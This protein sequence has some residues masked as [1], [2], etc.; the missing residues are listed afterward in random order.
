MGGH[1]PDGAVNPGIGH[2]IPPGE[3]LLLDVGYREKG[4]PCHKIGFRLADDSFDPPLFMKG[5]HF[6]GGGVKEVVGGEGQET[7]LNWMAEPKQLRAIPS[8]VSY[9]I[10][11]GTP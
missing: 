9:R 6:T 1:F 7:G 5:F 8:K 3:P 11:L 2:L 4:S 10:F